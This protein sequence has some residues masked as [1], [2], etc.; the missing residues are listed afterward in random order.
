M[1]EPV[2]K[3]ASEEMLLRYM[4]DEKPSIEVKI[5]K[6]KE[7]MNSA[8]KHVTIQYNESICRERITAIIKT[9]NRNNEYI[10]LNV[11]YIG[12]LISKSS[13]HYL[14]TLET[15]TGSVMETQ[16]LV[17]RKKKELKRLQWM[18]E[19]WF[20]KKKL[21]K[22]ERKHSFIMRLLEE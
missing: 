4:S 12:A 22:Y 17:R 13:W 6:W 18:N 11:H 9:I 7:R 16:E 5:E 19:Y 3:V 1:E 10:A 20:A 15:L 2:I 14:S 21:E 8:K